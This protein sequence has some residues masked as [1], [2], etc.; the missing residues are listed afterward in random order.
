M[1]GSQTLSEGPPCNC[2]DPH[3]VFRVVVNGEV[4]DEVTLNLET[5]TAE[6]DMDAVREKRIGLV[7]KHATGLPWRAES[8]CPG[9]GKGQV[10]I[11]GRP[12]VLNIMG[13]AWLGAPDPEPPLTADCGHQV[14]AAATTR[15][16]IANP[17]YDNVNVCIECFDADPERW[18]NP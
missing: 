2:D 10:T 6:A 12:K 11:T 1:S 9:C 16:R 18:K 13:K 4:L 17:D 15:E 5:P 3:Y 7:D 8:W 14:V